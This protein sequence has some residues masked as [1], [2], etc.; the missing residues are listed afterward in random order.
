MQA[1]DL[2]RGLLTVMV[3]AAMPLTGFWKTAVFPDNFR[4]TNSICLTA[5]FNRL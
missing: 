3:L 2:S 1:H 4:G 5:Y